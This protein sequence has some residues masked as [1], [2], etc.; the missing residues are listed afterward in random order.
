[1]HHELTV[2]EDE[3]SL[4]GADSHTVR[5]AFRAWVAD[6]LTPRLKSTERWGGQEEVRRILRSNTPVGDP[7]WNAERYHPA[8]CMPTRWQFCLFVD[9]NCLRS[10]DASADQPGPHVKLLNTDWKGD[11]S[12]NIAEGWED[13]E[14]DDETEDV[15]WM[16]MD[17]L[18]HVE[19]YRD[20][21]D[22]YTWWEMP[23]YER[24]Y[25]GFIP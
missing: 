15:G 22:S 18:E 1:M 10:L 16:Y 24:P 3:E 4:S 21:M 9:E 12:V 6:D 8:M 20:L 5:D 17:V 25:V 14:T 23:M 19:A 13:G 11:R 2:I 7:Y